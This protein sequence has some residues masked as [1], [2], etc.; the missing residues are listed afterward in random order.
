MKEQYVAYLRVS[1][2]RQGVSGLGLDAQRDAVRR[3]V[4]A[5]T[6]LHEYV[7]VETGKGRDALAK[8]PKLAEALA[9]CKK[10]GAVL[11]I[12]KLDRLS[13][14]VAFIAGLME[15]KIKFRACDLPEMNPLTVH[16]LAAFAEFEASRISER[17]KAALAQAKQRGVQLGTAGPKNLKPNVELR[18]Q[19]ADNYALNLQD[20][21]RDME[22]RQLT[23]K[24]MRDEF[25]RLGV[26]SPTGKAF[27]VGTVRGVRAR[28]RALDVQ[29]A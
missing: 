14:N 10:T 24:Q 8:R 2:Q 18:Q 15:S 7:E 20:L 11:L 26:K 17:I 28:L 25:N 12:A 13:R 1:T 23:E 22:R 21:I 3:F 6:I 27:I 5:A 19:Q 16:V 9:T 29:A 4:G